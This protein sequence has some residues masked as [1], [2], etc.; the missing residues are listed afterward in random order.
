VYHLEEGLTVQ[1]HIESINGLD[2]VTF[3][4]YVRQRQA[5]VAEYTVVRTSINFCDVN[6]QHLLSMP[7]SA[8]TGRMP[9]L[10][11]VPRNLKKPVKAGNRRMYISLI[12]YSRLRA[13]TAFSRN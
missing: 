12:I 6:S 3:K 1:A 9:K 2:D 7:S 13:G 10:N 11:L 5:L 8:R 4:E